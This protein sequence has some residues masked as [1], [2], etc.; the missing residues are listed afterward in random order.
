MPMSRGNRCYISGHIQPNEPVGGALGPNLV[1]WSRQVVMSDGETGLKAEF[2]MPGV[3]AR[4]KCAVG[5]KF[6]PRS[7]LLMIFTPSR[8]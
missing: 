3:H 7:I 5:Q 4:L 8:Q 6:D 1:R 2:Q